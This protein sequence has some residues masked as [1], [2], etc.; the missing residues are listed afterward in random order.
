MSAEDPIPSDSEVVAASLLGLP[1]RFEAVYDYETEETY[2]F[3]VHGQ[4]TAQSQARHVEGKLTRYWAL[5]VPCYFALALGVYGCLR[6]EMVLTA[7][8]I[9]VVSVFLGQ[10]HRS[11]NKNIRTGSAQEVTPQKLSFL[12]TDSGIAEFDQAV[13]SKIEWPAMTDWI[14]CRGTLFIQLANRK[15]AI[16]PA[17][18]IAPADIDLEK[19]CSLL[20]IK[21]VPGRIQDEK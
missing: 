9:L 19:L 12:I 14:L 2:H 10:Q 16:I 17:K 4:T 5:F 1:L 6:A 18:N 13:E 3:V 21:G 20:K 8:T 11:I 15:T 7:T